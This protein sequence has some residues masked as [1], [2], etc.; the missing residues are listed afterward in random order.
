MTARLVLA[1]A[2]IALVSFHV[3]TLREP[4]EGAL[5]GFLVGIGTGLVVAYGI[6]RLVIRPAVDFYIRQHERH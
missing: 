5:Q 6:D 2:A 1:L 4:L 3:L